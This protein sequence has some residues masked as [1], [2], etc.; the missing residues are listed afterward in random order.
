[1][2]NFTFMFFFL[3]IGAIAFAQQPVVT[4]VWDNSAYG[5][6]DWSQGFPV[7]EEIPAWM[8]GTTE[9]GMTHYDGKLYIVSR[10]EN[11]PVL[12]VLDAA[13][14]NHLES[15]PID[16][17]VVKGGTFAVNDIAITP[18]GK[19]LV[20]NLATN[21]HTQPFK[22]YMLEE[23]GE[24]GLD[25][26]VLLEWNSQDTIEGVAQPTY[27]LGDGFAFYGDIS[28]EEDGYIIVGDANTGTE[29]GDPD[30]IVFRWNV[31]AGVVVEEP[32]KIALQEVYPAPVG[33]APAKLG[34][35]P[36]IWP[37]D[38]DFFWA[39][40]HSTYPALYNMQG[41][42]ISTFS[43]DVT[44]ITGGISGVAFFSFKGHDFIL[45]PTTN[46]V[47]EPPAAFQLFLIPEAGAEEADSITVF[48]E[49]GLGLNTNASYAAPLAVDVQEDLVMMYIMSPNNGIAAFELTMGEDEEVPG[50]WNFSTSAFNALGDMAAD[51]TINGLTIFAKDDRKVTVDENSKTLGDLEFTH[52]LKLNGSGKFN[53][54]GSPYG[55]VLAFDV[56]GNT[57]IRV[58][59][60]SGSSG[61]DRELV[62]AYG[63]PDNELARFQALGAELTDSVIFYQGGP[64]T[65]YLYSSDSGINLYL[66][67]AES[68]PTNIVLKDIPELRVYPNPAT[69]RVFVKVNKPTQVAI[70]NL[71]GSMVKSRLIESQ[72]DFI[73]VSDLQPGMYLIK[74]QLSNEFTNK[75]IVK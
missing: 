46:H 50:L 44:P 52:R 27:R 35:T 71:A 15:M 47:T 55:R 70:Y 26:T 64:T 16:T 51:T 45:A 18:S 20:A 4:P 19:I 56:E 54:D 29:T 39:D 12:V 58:A 43:G 74:S 42:L 21:T 30:P 25:A 10:N 36:R 7:G 28:E 3:L 53:E 68:V 34:I 62:L 57:N 40:G 72:H 11:P 41:E 23:D 73:N 1:M 75:L 65:I 5:N 49:R 2:R 37:L 63:T 60:M 14:G 24:G 67:H 6:A 31:Q 38:N 9:R 69:D 32:V 8:G 48:P 33:E 13:T 61:S 22:V 66:L 59:A 17:S